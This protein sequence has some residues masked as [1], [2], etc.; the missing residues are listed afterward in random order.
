MVHPALPLPSIMPPINEHVLIANIG[1]ARRFSI[2]SA[3]SECDPV[4]SVRSDAM[5]GLSPLD[6]FS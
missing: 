2:R 3:S 5:S 4:Y 6:F 1:V